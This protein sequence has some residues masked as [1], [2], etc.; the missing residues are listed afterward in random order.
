M[1]ILPALRAGSDTV[2]VLVADKER[3]V[4]IWVQELCTFEYVQALCLASPVRSCQ[5]GRDEGALEQCCLLLEHSVSGEIQQ[6]VMV[7]AYI[8]GSTF[9]LVNFKVNSEG[10]SASSRGKEILTAVLD[11]T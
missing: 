9:K 11:K 7:E 8:C 2:T 5:H 6:G 10:S 1:S 4:S 3:R